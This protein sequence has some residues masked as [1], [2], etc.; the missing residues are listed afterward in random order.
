MF[1]DSASKLVTKTIKESDEITFELNYYM[2]LSESEKT[3]LKEFRE[4]YAKT[5][6]LHFNFEDNIFGFSQKKTFKKVQFIANPPKL[7]DVEANFINEIK[8]T[9]NKYNNFLNFD[10][11]ENLEKSTEMNINDVLKES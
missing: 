9:L 2:K 5:S 6:P 8:E 11:L 7:E 10:K 3:T 1:K 4:N